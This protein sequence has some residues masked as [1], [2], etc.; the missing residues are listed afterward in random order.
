MPGRGGNWKSKSEKRATK[1]T[2]QDFSR[3]AKRVLDFRFGPG[4]KTDDPFCI[5][6]KGRPLE[7][8]FYNSHWI[9]KKN[10][11]RQNRDDE[12]GW[13]KRP[14]EKYLKAWLTENSIIDPIP[15]DEAC[16]YED[17]APLRKPLPRTLESF[18]PDDQHEKR[19]PDNDD[20]ILRLAIA[21]SL[22]ENQEIQERSENEDLQEALLH[23]IQDATPALSWQDVGGSEHY[24]LTATWQEVEGLEGARDQSVPLSV[25]SWVNVPLEV[26][27]I[28]SQNVDGSRNGSP[29]T[30]QSWSFIE[31]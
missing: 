10:L 9:N 13:G 5:P 16:D 7:R 15:E 30:E 11:N 1:K 28:D 26:S 24:A 3:S 8:S 12:T 23:S 31:S 29:G 2:L 18:M 4:R 14:K 22:L 21:M 27:A 25:N 20:T 17:T 6:K 19:Q